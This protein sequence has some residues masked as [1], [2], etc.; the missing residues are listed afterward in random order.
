MYDIDE[1]SALYRNTLYF[2]KHRLKFE[3]LLNYVIEMF[4]VES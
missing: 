1:N 4:F 3:K 2:S